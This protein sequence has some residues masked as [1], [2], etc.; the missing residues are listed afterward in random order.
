MGLSILLPFTFD[1]DP[2][3]AFAVLIGLH[4]VI[5]TADTMPAVL[6]GI[7]GTAASQATILDGHPMAKR[8]EAGRALGAAYMASLMGGLFGA[9]VLALSVP[10][11]RPLVLAFGAPEFF[12][13]GMLGISMVAVLG[14]RRPLKGLVVGV[15][16]LLVGAVGGDPQTGIL[17]WTLDQPYLED[18]IPL[19]PVSLGIF[20]IP[21]IADLVVKG[22][23]IA[24]VPKDATRGVT[25]G[26]RDA[27][28]H[29]F[30]VLRCSAVGTWVGFIPGLGASVVDWFAY[31]HA[32]Q[33]IKD[34]RET[35]GTGDVR[36]VI[37]PESANNAKEGG[38]L[39]PTIAFGVP[40]GAAMALLLGAF[41]IQGLIPG[42]DMLTRHLDVTYT[43][44]WSIAWPTFSAPAS[45]C[46][47]PTRSPRSR[48]SG[49][50]SRSPHHRGRSVGRLPGHALLWRPRGPGVLL[51]P[52]LAHEAFR[53]APAASHSGHGSQ[54]HRRA[55]IFS[56][57][58]TA[59]GSPGSDTPWSS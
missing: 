46:S 26:I 4:S 24:D 6:F 14:G 34:A 53:M 30:L 1:M 19:V 48:P 20:A 35:F 36:G 42:P 47:S 38:V 29:W 7:P 45:A 11:F 52:G 49:P 12:M 28:R 56:S 23:R 17:R 16:G 31:G 13:L 43:I 9:V 15:I 8:G 40:G 58:S 21:E 55:A 5:C 50:T 57:R 54:Q 10:V 22:T 25:V 39:I 44:V 41:T 18:G 2:F 37:A 32:A 27:F 33:S 3:T 51:H 59:T